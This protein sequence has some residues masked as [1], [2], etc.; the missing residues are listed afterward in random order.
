MISEA[1]NYVRV[2]PHLLLF[3][4]GFLAVTVLAFVMLGDAVRE[5]FDPK[6][7]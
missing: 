2:S 6:S 5:A 3:P 1:R 4:A 7:R